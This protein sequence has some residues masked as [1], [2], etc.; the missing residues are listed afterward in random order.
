MMEALEI[1]FRRC[2]QRRYPDI[3]DET[4]ATVAYALWH[5]ALLEQGWEPVPLTWCGRTVAVAL[6]NGPEIHFE[7]LEDGAAGAV[8][9]LERHVVRPTVQVYGFASTTVMADNPGGL[10]FCRRMGFEGEEE[11]PDGQIRLTRRA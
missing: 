8:R 1:A 6:V 4:A 7:T 11:T 10:A 5:K 9:A 2:M 3:Q